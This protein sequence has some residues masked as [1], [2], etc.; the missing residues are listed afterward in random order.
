MRDVE[1]TMCPDDI[2]KTLLIGQSRI[3]IAWQEPI[4]SLEDRDITVT[5]SHQ[6]GDAFETG[7]TSVSYTAVDSLGNVGFCNFSIIVT[8]KCYK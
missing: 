2:I 7:R 5:A 4:I 1:F 3:F 6:P 8:G